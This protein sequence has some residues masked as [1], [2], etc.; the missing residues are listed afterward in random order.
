MRLGVL[1]LHGG[2]AS[3]GSVLE[4]PSFLGC[5]DSFV[6]II[7]TEFST[8]LALG[9]QFGRHFVQVRHVQEEGPVDEVRREYLVLRLQGHHR[10]L[11]TEGEGEGEEDAEER[12]VHRTPSPSGP[13]GKR[14]AERDSVG[15][16]SRYLRIDASKELL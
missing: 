12:T 8:I 15:L 2:I 7:R 10:L 6:L 9:V 16:D 11:A 1:R 14:R 4:G 13:S 5:E 3:R